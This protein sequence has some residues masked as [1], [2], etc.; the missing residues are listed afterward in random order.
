MRLVRT[1]IVV[2]AG[3]G[4]VA[5]APS[6]D[7]AKAKKEHPVKGV[8]ASVDR[9]KDK[10]TG[11]ITVHIPEHKN[12]KT[13]ETKPAEDKPIKVTETTTFVKVSGKKGAETKE[14]ATFADV[15]EGDH[16]VV[17]VQDGAAVE[18]AIHPHH[19]KKGA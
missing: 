16:L 7:A 2:V 15:K 5:L 8:V 17:T 6:A 3:L 18:V 11:T 13:N 4:L 10:G 9:D 1:L 12:K 14:P 19:K